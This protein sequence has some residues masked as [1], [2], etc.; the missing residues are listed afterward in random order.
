MDWMKLTKI[1]VGMIVLSCAG[2]GTY[3][4]TNE[5]PGA[6]LDRVPAATFNIPPAQAVK[7][8]QESI[9]NPPLSLTLD[10]AQDGV[11]VTGWKEYE[12]VLHIVRRWPERTRYFIVVNPD[13]NDPG[14]MCRVLVYDHTQEK[15]EERQGWVDNSQ[16]YRWIRANE[17]LQ[18]IQQKL[19]SPAPAAK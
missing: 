12:G 18:A 4:A 1:A 19:G 6:P 3:Q 10:S 11:I 2:C 17:V 15:A 16:L 13:F 9:V 5:I 14:H 8:I 7:A